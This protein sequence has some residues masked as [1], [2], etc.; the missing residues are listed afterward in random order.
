MP[1]ENA[2]Y[3][4]TALSVVV[5]VISLILAGMIGFEYWRLRKI[6]LEFQAQ[7]EA[8]DSEITSRERSTHRILASY[9]V[10]DPAQR[11]E[12]L[13]SAIQINSKTFNAFNA[14]GYAYLEINERQKAVDAFRSAVEHHPALKEGYCDLA[15]AYLQS[16]ERDLCIGYLRQ[17]IRTD[18]SARDDLQTDRRF[19]D[20][21]NEV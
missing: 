2:S 12:L 16:G 6:R 14:L 10:R 20:V 17:A 1:L 15:F 5:S 18:S 3:I 21:V 11:I 8:L 13:K 7:K 4:A 19:A 9:Q